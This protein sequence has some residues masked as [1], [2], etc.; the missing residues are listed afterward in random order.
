MM[1]RAKGSAGGGE[2]DSMELRTVVYEGE[3]EDDILPSPVIR[4]QVQSQ[5]EQKIKMASRLNELDMTWLALFGTLR[6]KHMIIDVWQS[7]T[8]IFKTPTTASRLR[9]AAALE[10]RARRRNRAD[11]VN[12]SL[13]AESMGKYVR[14]VQILLVVVCIV[15]SIFAIRELMEYGSRESR[16][17]IQVYRYRHGISTADWNYTESECCSTCKIEVCND[18]S[19]NSNDPSSTCGPAHTMNCLNISCVYSWAMNKSASMGESFRKEYT[20]M[21]NFVRRECEFKYCRNDHLAEGMKYYRFDDETSSCDL[22]WNGSADGGLDWN[23]FN[24]PQ[25]R[26]YW[27]GRI[28]LWVITPAIVGMVVLSLAVPELLSR[29]FVRD[30]LI[31]GIIAFLHGGFLYTMIITGK[32]GIGLTSVAIIMCS[33]ISVIPLAIR[34]I[35]NIGM[36]MTYYVYIMGETWKWI[37]PR[38]EVMNVPSLGLL[39]NQWAATDLTCPNIGK[40]QYVISPNYTRT[41]VLASPVLFTANRAIYLGLITVLVMIPALSREILSRVHQYKVMS[42]EEQQTETS[43]LNMLKKALL[44]ELIP[45]SIIPQVKSG[46]L[47]AE[48]FRDVTI[49]FTDLKGFTAMS[50]SIS[51][52]K[53]LKFLNN[54]YTKF[55]LI[56]SSNEVYKVEVIGDAYFVVGGCPNRVSHAERCEAGLFCCELNSILLILT[57]SKMFFRCNSRHVVRRS[58]RQGLQRCRRDAACS[59][60]GLQRGETRHLYAH[61]HAHWRSCGWCSRNEGPEIPPVW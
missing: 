47:V 40:P 15:N 6:A 30:A 55:D 28:R 32:P 36:T 48:K 58:R 39:R 54:L 45:E 7:T 20:D 22:C 14:L 8:E 10:T 19:F 4:Q 61:R 60:E 43:E 29:P 57:F 26:V 49:M 38:F 52:V 5:R 31:I 33:E 42:I 21:N 2:R 56:L 18:F 34:I 9:A 25:T 53:L 35:L 23:C 13:F 1:A 51:P 44:A 46:A 16:D 37:D 3:E 59:R 12:A 41:D 50:S 17:D 27:L 24:C 11:N